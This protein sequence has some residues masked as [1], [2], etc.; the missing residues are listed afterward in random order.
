MT[1]QVLGCTKYTIR[2]H[3][4]SLRWTPQWKRRPKTT[5]RR[6]D[7]KEIKAIGLT[8]S[9]LEMGALDRFKNAICRPV[10]VKLTKFS[11]TLKLKEINIQ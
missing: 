2:V 6:T 11:K 5:W 1:L 4:I 3:S 7:E 8:W 10:L 9:E